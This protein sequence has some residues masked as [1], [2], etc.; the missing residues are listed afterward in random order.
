[1]LGALRYAVLDVLLWSAG[2]FAVMAGFGLYM[3]WN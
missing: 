2:T 3:G 1:M